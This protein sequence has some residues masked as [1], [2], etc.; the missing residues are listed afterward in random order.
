MSR[1]DRRVVVA[2]LVIVTAAAQ[3]GLAGVAYRA[4]CRAGE[5]LAA[6]RKHLGQSAARLRAI[7]AQPLEPE[8]SGASRWRLAVEPD[9]SRTLQVLQGIGDAH[10]V[11]LDT[12]EVLRSKAAEKCS[13]RIA[14]AAAPALVCA[15]LAAIEDLEDVV[16]VETGRIHPGPDGEIA[17]DFGLATFH[18]KQ[19][20]ER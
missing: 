9:V 10:G 15:L 4:R 2:A 13:F 16:V 19:E 20:Q 18:P 14:G 7:Q 8:S 5:E 17:F 3:A 11:E 1:I 12:L 6:A